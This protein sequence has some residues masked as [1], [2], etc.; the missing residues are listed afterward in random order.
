MQPSAVTLTAVDAAFACPHLLLHTIHI[1]TCI[2][3]DSNP[4]SRYKYEYSRC[5]QWGTWLRFVAAVSGAAELLVL[6]K[7]QLANRVISEIKIFFV[8]YCVCPV[9]RF[10]CFFLSFLSFCFFFL[11]FS[12]VFS[13][14]YTFI[15][16]LSFFS[17]FHFIPLYIFISS[18]H[19]YLLAPV[20]SC[21]FHILRPIHPYVLVL[22]IGL[23]SPRRTH[24]FIG[25]LLCPLWA[26]GRLDVCW[27]SHSIGRLSKQ[28][29]YEL[30]VI[31]IRSAVCLANVYR[32]ELQIETSLLWKRVT[33]FPQ[34][35][36]ACVHANT[37][38]QCAAV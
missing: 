4:V 1:L 37:V 35:L 5:R 33:H 18:F 32:S 27:D 14:S 8:C 38:L 12:L 36:P 11:Y 10:V 29:M 28:R 20:A 15:S 7:Q 24:S 22:R 13:F 17:P 6:M 23:Y 26:R 16:I 19:T 31:V 2:E 3:R 9:R 21:F 34:K 30:P 25:R